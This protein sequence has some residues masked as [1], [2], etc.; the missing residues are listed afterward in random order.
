MKIRRVTP[1]GCRF[2]IYKNY[3][4]A[5]KNFVLT[6]KMRN[7][8]INATDKKIIG[9]EAKLKENI[10]DLA[11]IQF[12]NGLNEGYYF[13]NKLNKRIYSAI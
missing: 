2:R 10:F 8:V 9:I 4:T 5:L 6:E 11:F 1:E 7:F 12:P 13:I 3:L